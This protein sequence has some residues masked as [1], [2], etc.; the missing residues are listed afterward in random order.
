MSDVYENNKVTVNFD[1][2]E[3]IMLEALSLLLDETYE[4]VIKIAIRNLC[5]K[6]KTSQNLFHVEKP[7]AS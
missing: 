4:Q 5:C 1:K 6:E 7:D 3:R 2:T